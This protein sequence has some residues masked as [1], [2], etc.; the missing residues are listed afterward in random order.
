MN[1]VYIRRNPPHTHNEDE[2]GGRK[3][4]L[5]YEHMDTPWTLSL[6]EDEDDET[7]RPYFGS[8]MGERAVGFR[9]QTR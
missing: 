6:V 1:G 9:C 3:Y 5:H 8:S 2:E 4:M 7:R